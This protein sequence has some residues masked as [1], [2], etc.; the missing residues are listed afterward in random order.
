[1]TF[2]PTVLLAAITLAFMPVAVL[3][4]VEGDENQCTICFDDED[5]LNITGS[6]QSYREFLD[7]LAAAEVPLREY[8]QDSLA[9]IEMGSS[10]AI[11]DFS[12][13]YRYRIDEQNA[14]ELQNRMIGQ[15]MQQAL[16]LGLNYFL[17][18]SGAVASSIRTYGTRAY[19]AL[20]SQ[21]PDGTTDPGPYLE[22]ISENLE[23]SSDRLSNFMIDMF[24]GT[25]DQ[26]LR[27]QMDMIKMEYVWEKSWQREEDHEGART[28][29]PGDDTRRLLR[30]IGIGPG[31]SPT[32]AALREQVLTRLIREVLCVEHRG[33]PIRN[34]ET[35]GWFFD[36]VAKGSALRL[37]V[38][39]SPARMYPL[40]DRAHLDRVCP[41]ERRLSALEQ[42]S[43]CRQWQQGS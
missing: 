23:N 11:R 25:G 38:T 29:S 36:V 41:V 31:G 1:M 33:N 37:I 22:R 24:Q 4:Q 34:C 15:F 6:V 27:D 2:L 20:V 12:H 16:E 18:G 40:T 19:G 32:T 26:A 21:M 17:P 10:R 28:R 5:G 43:D 8:T 14:D 35:D 30:E 7:Q 3:A 13:W 39:E 42:G 9:S